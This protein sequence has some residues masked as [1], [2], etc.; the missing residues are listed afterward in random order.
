MSNIKISN[1]KVSYNTSPNVVDDVSVEFKEGVI[2]GIIGESGSG[3]SVLVMSILK[4]LSGNAN[5]TGEILYKDRNLLGI[6]EEDMNKIRGA[7][8]AFI[9]QNPI[10]AF[11]PVLKI[12]TQ[13][14]EILDAHSDLSKNAKTQLMCKHLEMVGFNN[15]KEILELYPLT[16]SGGMMQRVIALYGSLASPDWIIADEP[17]KGLDS[18]LRNQIIETFRKIYETTTNNMIIITHDLELC[19]HLCGEVII[20]RKGKIIEQGET[21]EVF[22]NPKAE[23]SKRL[24]SSTPSNLFVEV[25][26]D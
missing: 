2:T 1:L 6:N 26:D 15:P 23:Y 25:Q 14:R 20:M 3:K 17:S 11:N 5:I 21:V 13:L 7:E 4:L 16:L 22:K 9:P 12:D 8:I 24:I 18:I 19:Y 10:E